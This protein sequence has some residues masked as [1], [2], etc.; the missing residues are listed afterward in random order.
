MLSKRLVNF[1]KDLNYVSANV[2]GKFKYNK[3]EDCSWISTL[4]LMYIELS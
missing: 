2:K 3:Y 1:S 4:E